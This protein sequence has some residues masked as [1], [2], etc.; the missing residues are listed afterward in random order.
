M[1]FALVN[2][3]ECAFLWQTTDFLLDPFQRIKLKR[4]FWKSSVKSQVKK[5]HFEVG[6]WGSVA[7]FIN[8]NALPKGDSYNKLR[9]QVSYVSVASFCFNS[10]W[11][12]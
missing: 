4:T 10:S 3:W 6:L 7:L 11:T 1:R 8:I 12:K 2:T 5:M 9:V